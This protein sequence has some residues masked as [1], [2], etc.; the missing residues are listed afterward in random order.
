MSVTPET[1]KQRDIDSIIHPYTHLSKH[2]ETG[3]LV[4][5]RAE[6]PY[7]WDDKGNKYIEALAG[8]WCT[9]LG[10]GNEELCQ[11]AYDQMK[12]LS[13]AP[14]FAGKT[15]E[16]GIELAEKLKSL[17]PFD[18]GKVFYGNS[19]SDANDTQIKLLWY[20]NNARGKP[21]KKKMIGRVKGYH[22]IT[23]AAG[24][25]TGI[26]PSHTGFDLPLDGGRF[27]HTDT[28]HHYRYAEDGESEEDFA[29]R[30]ANNLEQLILKEGPETVA[31]FIAEPIMAAGGVIV[32][33]RTYFQKIQSVLE[34]YDVMYV[35]DEVVCGFGRTGNPFGYDT[36]ELQ[37][38]TVTMAK[39]LTSAYQPLSAV[40]IKDDMF[41]TMVDAADEMGVF[42]H[43]YTY[44]GHPVACAVGLKTLEIYERD[45]I[46]DKA[47]AL[48]P[49]FQQRL[50][51][52][53][54]H[55][56][57]GEVRGAGLLGAIE[58]VANKETKALFDPPGTVGAH[59]VQQCHANGLVIRPLGDTMGFCPPLI[60]T[61]EQIDEIFDKFEKSLDATT[62]WAMAE[63]LLKT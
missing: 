8:L 39:A 34:K 46:F 1:L 60:V 38:D 26:L 45:E 9:A 43:G 37:P 14:I 57:V 58:F 30:L 6:G 62:Q 51:S 52:F 7:I 2:L 41:K 35:D 23:M 32:P 12:E 48:T 11:T 61:P 4:F 36:F 56:M 21:E 15:H 31:G 18:G 19:G 49:H 20:Y 50:R 40:V 29:T 54:D 16:V 28:P 47:A 22:G 24:S 44:S 63:G 13:Y 55:P 59:C 25:L 53:A 3:P 5:T 42:G 17:M 27:L 10:Y 33:P